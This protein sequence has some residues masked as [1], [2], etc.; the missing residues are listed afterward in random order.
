MAAAG[1]GARTQDAST[2]LTNPAGMVNV[3]GTRVLVG[4]QALY[5][6]MPFDVDSPTSPGLGSKGGNPIGWFPGGGTYITHSISPDLSVGFAATGTFGLAEEYDDDWAGR[7]YIQQ[8]ALL[9]VSV[10]PA[11]AYRLG[12]SVSVGAAMNAM[13]GVLQDQLAVNNI[14]GPDG[15]LKVDDTAWG[16]GAN[17]GLL[18]DTGAGTRVGLVYTSQVSLGFEAPAEFSNLSDGLRSVLESRGLIDAEI[19]LGLDI[20]QTVMLSGYQKVAPGTALLGSV[21]WQQWSQ[22]GRVEV[23]VESS[24]PVSLTTESVFNDTW[25]G[26]LGLQHQI[27]EKWRADVGA[28][29]DSGFQKDGNFSPALPA[30]SAW[31][32]G[33]GVKNQVRPGLGWGV[34][35]EYVYGGTLDVTKK[36]GAPVAVGGRGDLIGSFDQT[37]MVFLSGNIEWRF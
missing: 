37:S 29:Y 4:L 21:G 1:Y 7:Y 35:A 25:N 13:Y 20:P 26:A 10:L 16:F 22:F 9:G 34:A 32:F 24:D 28:G 27:A 17:L 5:G 14:T 11:I 30:N 3:E 8:G 31:R 2:V 33:L 18:Y 36:G 15:Q 12:K 6:N 23:G 19:D